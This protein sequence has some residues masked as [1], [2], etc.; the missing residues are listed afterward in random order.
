VLAAGEARR[1][2]GQKLLLR[3]AGSTVIGC[4]VEALEQAGAAPVVVVVGAPGR[5]ALQAALSDTAAQIV[6]NPD[7]S[8]GMLSSLRAGLAALP[9]ATARFLIA[10]GDQPRIRAD[11]IMH[12]LAEQRR[13]GRGIAIAAHQGKRGHPVAFTSAYR[14][15]IMA[16]RDEQALRDLI[17]AHPDDVAVVE[18]GSDA[19]TSD[20]DTQEDYE[21]ELGRTR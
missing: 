18:C 9:A 15:Q 7:P 13:L 3:F 19:V 6:E 21:R 11:E 8:R 20:I 12:L 14:E 1:L 17:H 5:A 10:L 16:L 4:V 2:G